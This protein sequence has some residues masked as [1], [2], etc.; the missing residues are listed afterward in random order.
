MQACSL[1]LLC[2][3]LLGGGPLHLPIPLDGV[4]ALSIFFFFFFFECLEM[5]E[6]FP[7]D[8]S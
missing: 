1:V 8:A 2:A 3:V 7:K 5:M 4:L 6:I